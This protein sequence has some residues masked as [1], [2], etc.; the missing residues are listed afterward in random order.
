MATL[1]GDSLRGDKS[2]NRRVALAAIR[3]AP[4]LE[5]PET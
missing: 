1:V 4:F 2:A 3:T 5:H